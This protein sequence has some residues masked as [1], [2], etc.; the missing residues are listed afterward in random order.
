M[1]YAIITLQLLAMTVAVAATNRVHKTLSPEEREKRH[2]EFLRQTGGYVVKPDPGNGRILIANAQKR[3][4]SRAFSRVANVARMRMKL[5][6]ESCDVEVVKAAHPTA[7]SARELRATLVVFVTDDPSSKSTILL[8]PDERWAIVNVSALGIDAPDAETV[9]NRT[10]HAVSRAVGFLCGAGGSQ[11]AD[12]LIGAFIDCPRDY[13]HFK[14][15][16]LPPDTFQ[17]LHTYLG[18]LGVRPIEQ[19]TYQA[20]C[21][22]GWAPAPTNDI[23]KAIWEKVH[24]APTKPIKITYDK[25]KQKPVVK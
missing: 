11:Y 21:Q 13:D 18:K 8:S 19:I 12:S 10:R 24:A 2:Q 20:A 23:Q 4:P 15:D 9:E 6:I 22:E 1:K 25:D 17:K 14:S 7:I 3:V 5:A 16:M